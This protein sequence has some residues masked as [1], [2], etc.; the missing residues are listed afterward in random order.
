MSAAHVLDALPDLAAGKAQGFITSIAKEDPEPLSR[1]ELSF[2]HS[3]LCM[4]SLPRA[5][6]PGREYT[7]QYRQHWVKVRSGELDLGGGPE[8]RAM[9]HGALARLVMIWLTTKVVQTKKKE[10]EIPR[11]SRAWLAELGGSV[12]TR[13]AARL[14]DA[15]LNLLASDWVLGKVGV[16]EFWRLA[17]TVDT[18]GVNKNWPVRV[19]LSGD[20]FEE[21]VTKR[22]AMPLCADALRELAGS[23]LAL[24]LYMWLVLRGHELKEELI[25]PWA[26]LARQHGHHAQGVHRPGDVFR[27]EAK[28]ALQLVAPHFGQRLQIEKTGLLILPEG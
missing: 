21:L 26:A 19:T 15:V 13:R 5:P 25:V 24:D 10:V 1:K 16:T 27:R 28:E 12:D 6:H 17:K 9:P 18:T 22:Q 2:S 3:T 23:A 11:S 20:F 14:N 7:K 8:E 4:V